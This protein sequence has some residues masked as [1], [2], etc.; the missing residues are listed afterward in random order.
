MQVIEPLLN[1]IARTLRQNLYVLE[2]GKTPADM[3]NNPAALKSGKVMAYPVQNGKLN[4]DQLVALTNVSGSQCNACGAVPAPQNTDAS[5]GSN[6]PE[7]ATTAGT[8]VSCEGLKMCQRCQRAWYCSRECQLAA[9]KS[10]KATCRSRYAFVP[11]DVAVLCNLNSQPELNGSVVTILARD[12]REMCTDLAL[13]KW[14]VAVAGDKSIIV[15]ASK[16]ERYK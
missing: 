12:E 11:G 1:D 16:L 6:P 15:T 3:F 5:D 14:Q 10:H 13:Q 4:P 9:W 8:K 2:T 7:K